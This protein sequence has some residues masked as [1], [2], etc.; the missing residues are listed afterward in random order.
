MY[1]K[2]MPCDSPATKEE[3]PSPQENRKAPLRIIANHI[4]FNSN[5]V[6][7]LLLPKALGFVV[8]CTV[9]LSARF[10]WPRR[11]WRPRR[12][13]GSW[14]RNCVV[15]RLPTAGCSDEYGTR[16]DRELRECGCRCMNE[17]AIG[18]TEKLIRS[19]KEKIAALTEGTRGAESRGR[20][21][22][23]F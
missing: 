9:S 18:T 4:L 17:R 8:V 5:T 12:V 14:S 22:F 1:N 19:P 13:Q 16:Y 11:Q 23:K 7:H 6:F 10:S 15:G 2:R 3:L 21:K 20:Q